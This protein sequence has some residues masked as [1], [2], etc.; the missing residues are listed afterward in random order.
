MSVYYVALS[1]SPTLDY[2]LLRAFAQNVALFV[3]RSF[4]QN[5]VEWRRIAESTESWGKGKRIFQKELASKLEYLPC[6]PFSSSHSLSS[7]RGVEE[8]DKGNYRQY[9]SLYNNT[10]YN[11][12]IFMNFYNQ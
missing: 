5:R 4:A 8:R 2:A 7:K 12:N 3:S 9:S 6:C 1:R 11:S 10:P